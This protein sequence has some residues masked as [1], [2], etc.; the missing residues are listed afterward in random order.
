MLA[1][2][3]IAQP[4]ISS[5][6]IYTGSKGASVG[7]TGT[8]FNASIANNIV[9]F[10]A[11]KA[12][13]SSMTSTSINV[14]VPAGATFQPVSVLNTGTN[15][16]GYCLRSFLPTFSNAPY[17]P[18]AIHFDTKVDFSTSGANPYGVVI[19]DI[20]GDG[21]ADMVVANNASNTI[22]VYRNTS[23]TGAITSGSFGSPV[24]FAT[25]SG[26]GYLKTADL[27]ADGKPE[28][29]V[30]NT[31]SGT[32]SVF[33]NTASSGSISSSSLATKVDFSAGTSAFDVAV[34]DFDG[35]GKPDL[36]VTNNVST[37]NTISVL[38]NTTSAGSISTSSFASAVTF[39]TGSLPVKIVV[40][41]FDGD[42][43]PDIAVTNSSSNSVSVFR[44]T[45]SSGAITTSSFASKVDFTTGTNPRGIFAADMD[46]DGK[47]DIIVTNSASNTISVFRNTTTSSAIN[48]SSF[49]TQVNFTTGTTPYD[50]AMG[51]IDGNGKPDI[52][53]TN[54]GA[55]TISVFRN[56]GS[57]GSITTSTF[58]SKSDFTTG[59][60]GSPYGIAIS[61]LDGDGKVDIA[62]ANTNSGGSVSVL[63]N[64]ILSPVLNAGIVCTGSSRLLSDSVSGGTWSTN[65][66]AVATINSSG[67]VTALAAGNAIITYSVTGGNDTALIT[68]SALPSVAGITSSSTNIC[69]GSALTFTAGAV[70]GTGTLAS[71]N[72]SGP[73][74]YSTTST[75]T[76]A[77]FTPTS[78]AASGVYSLTVT[79][80]GAGCTSIAALTSPSVTVSPAA[81]AG[82]ISGTSSICIGA[83]ATLTNATGGGS[84]SSSNS[85]LAS[86]SGGAVTGLS[87]GTTTI[88]YTVSTACS[89]ASA[90]KVVTVNSMQWLGG[91]S[92]NW[93]T[94]ANWSCG[95]V[96]GA[97]DNV[98]IP[99]GTVYVPLIT[100]SAITKSLTIA[101]GVTITTNAGSSLT[102]NGHLNG[103][104]IS[105]NG[106]ITLNGTNPQT[107]SGN[108]T[109]SNFELNN[110][111]GATIQA[112]ARLTIK[113]A[114]TITAGTLVTNDSLVL[115]SDSAAT[116]RIA[117]LPSSGAAI[118]GNVKV[119]QYIIGGMR[120]YRFWSHPFSDHTALT[121][122]GNYIDITG[123]GGAANG[124]TT[125]PSNAPSVIRYNPLVGNSSLPCDPGWRPFTSAFGDAD[126][127]RIHPYQGIRLFVRGNKGEGLGY[128]TYN[129][130]P[131]TIGMSGHVNQGNQ[132]IHLVKGAAGNQDYNMVGNPFAS[133]VD[134]GTIIYNA[135][136][137]GAI[138]GSCFYV[139]VPSLGAGG[140]FL[141]QPIGSSSPIPYYL[142][143][144]CA[145]QVRAAHNGD[146][147]IFTENNKSANISNSLLKATP[148]YVSLTVLDA[149]YHPWDILYL[150]F[151]DAATDDDDDRDAAKPQGMDFNFYSWSADHHKLALDARP[152]MSGKVIPL[153][154]TSAYAQDFIIKAGEINLPEG[155]Q[156]LLHD[157]VLKQNILLKQGTEYKFNITT[158]KEMQGNNRFELEM[159]TLAEH[160]NNKSLQA[161]VAPNPATSEVH[162]AYTNIKTAKTSVRI[163]AVSGSCVYH[164]D[165]GNQSSGTI[166]VPLATFTPGIYMVE[167]TSGEQKIIHRLLKE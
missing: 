139:W 122:L 84:W 10:G 51:D 115:F 76:T 82:T 62:V 36:A 97:N 129:P 45:A 109:L 22:S 44:N 154:I 162:I 110:S 71:Y 142:Q 79:Y 16:T 14:I 146:S 52:I 147:L 24:T 56:I 135:K 160:N 68:V 80:P 155:T 65:A 166:S 130:S 164:K 50:V 66:P 121:T 104:A 3:A 103:N 1:T 21:N 9:Y 85:T 49:G 127:N 18:G 165:Y 89:S 7:I 57:T 74:S 145:F 163:F 105:G 64:N 17:V 95:F 70:S 123:A 58:T 100:A 28:I 158:D 59:G 114:L 143:A 99:A 119:M 81:N 113:N 20:D 78:T 108:V 128:G 46:N 106:S 72:W 102:I 117:P 69:T 144:N 13:I 133:P 151:N 25:G 43:K 94:A 120:R 93:N 134:I 12:T 54:F 83:T 6:S 156:L 112:G 61:D 150:D 116:A 60:T 132:I 149:N 126:S 159:E 27:D 88:S 26:P 152:Y 98:T 96:P 48:T 37:A 101:T 86:V 137:A 29:I 136:A 141:A 35:D 42:S 167:F 157:K 90:T 91:T 87:A 161:T 118:S 53:V 41:D 19:V 31:T 131:V 55:T 140:Q 77:V 40:A 67:L 75:A 5:L 38:R 125:T 8:N 15:L 107:I 73:N 30:A 138:T 63:R 33:K 153:G 124:F 34:S 4:V 11:T 47:F 23:T 39:A 32:I 111:S 92:S 148:E 2:V